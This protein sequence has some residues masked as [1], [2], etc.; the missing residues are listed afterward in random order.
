M[1][2]ITT[3]TTLLKSIKA[4]ANLYIKQELL[5]LPEFPFQ[6]DEMVKIEIHD[7]TLVI[8]KPQWWEML[9]WNQALHAWKNLPPEIKLTITEAG[10]APVEF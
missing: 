7:D 8:L 10:L 3:F 6:S 9:D 1:N 5:E 2:H 4:G